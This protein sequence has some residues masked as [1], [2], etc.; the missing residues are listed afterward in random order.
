MT[1]L[2]MNIFLKRRER[3]SKEWPEAQCTATILLPHELKH[4]TQLQEKLEGVQVPQL[5]H[6]LQTLHQIKPE[7]KLFRSRQ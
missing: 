3:R 5:Y 4:H 1:L 2:S 6:P 7:L